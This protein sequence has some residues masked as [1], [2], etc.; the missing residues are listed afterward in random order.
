[1]AEQTTLQ[2][3]GNNPALLFV[4]GH[5]LLHRAAFGFPTRIRS[6]SGKDRTMVFGFFA[7]LRAAMRHVQEDVECIAIFDGIRGAEGRRLVEPNYKP[8]FPDTD[9]DAFSDLP[10]LHT[11]LNR[12]GVRVVEFDDYEA[13][14][15]IATSVRHNVRDRRCLIM[16]TDRDFY[17]LLQPDCLL[18]N[19]ARRAADRL[20]GPERV[21]EQYGVSTDQWCDFRAL[22]GDPSD[23][24]PGV[25]GIGPS[26][27]RSL[28]RGGMH[29]EDLVHREGIQPPWAASIVGQ[30]DQL[31][32]W[33]DLMRLRDDLG[34]D[35]T[36]GQLTPELPP[37][38]EV[39]GA[40][41]LW[42]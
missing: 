25:R 41:G 6:R 40:I 9:P 24:I 39:L 42:E 3:V 19:T 34:L 32:K 23:G 31:L 11:A 37:A 26:R 30:R 29:L 33:R 35:V 7:L 14:D 13:D 4:D 18:L 2:L 1:M 22:V 15:V 5:N 27:A 12:Y 28:L 36:N 8:A 16:S 17:Q 38:P 20:V 10:V 21:L